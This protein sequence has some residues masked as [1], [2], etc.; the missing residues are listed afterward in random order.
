MTT[1]S[2]YCPGLAY[3]FAEREREGER[4][5]ERERERVFQVHLETHVL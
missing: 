3:T 2:L 4:E 5:R 1:R